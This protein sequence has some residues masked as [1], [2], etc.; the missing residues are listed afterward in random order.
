[1]P[2]SATIDL[3][4]DSQAAIDGINASLKA[5]LTPRWWLKANNDS[6]ISNIKHRINSL[7]LVIKL[8]K[9]KG[10]SGNEHNERVDE[11]A[12]QAVREAKTDPSLI[13]DINNIQQG[14]RFGP[15]WNGKYIDRSLRKFISIM[16]KNIITTR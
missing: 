3:F 4:T 14:L 11:L 9:I 6:L 12:K 2:P 5:S 13:L 16:T 10:H 1:M 7:Q 8:H 15:K